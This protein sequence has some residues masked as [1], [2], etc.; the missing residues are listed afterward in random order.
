MYSFKFPSFAVKI[1]YSYIIIL[2][3]SSHTKNGHTVRLE[4]MKK[5]VRIPWRTR[6]ESFKNGLG[7]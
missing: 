2:H 7:E 1:V 3:A 6:E 4:N 5:E